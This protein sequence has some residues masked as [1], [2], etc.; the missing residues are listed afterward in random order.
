MIIPIR[1]MKAGRSIAERSSAE[2]KM[3][4][5]NKKQRTGENQKT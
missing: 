4:I 3:F 5:K 2:Q 1:M